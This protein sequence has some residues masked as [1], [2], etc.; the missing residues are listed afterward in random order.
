MCYAKGSH[1]KSVGIYYPHQRTPA[2]DRT[3]ENHCVIL[4][5]LD[6]EGAENVPVDEKMG[7]KG[8]FRAFQ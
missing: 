3:F 1:A 5:K 7:V 6:T 4:A 2:A 8:K